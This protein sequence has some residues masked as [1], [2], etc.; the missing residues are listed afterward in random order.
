MMMISMNY[1]SWNYQNFDLIYFQIYLIIQI[2]V[3]HSCFDYLHQ[4]KIPFLNL[5]SFHF[6]NHFINLTLNYHFFYYHYLQNFHFEFINLYQK[7]LN[8]LRHYYPSI[9]R[10]TNSNS[11]SI[12]P[13]FFNYLTFSSSSIHFFCYKTPL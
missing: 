7:Y 2:L 11:S 12:K 13:N 10:G 6:L 9:I 5:M 1:L 3:L 4:L 8:F